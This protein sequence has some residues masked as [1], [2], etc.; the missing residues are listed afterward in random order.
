MQDDQGTGF[1]FD[2]GVSV[3]GV[4]Q[5]CAQ[6]QEILA[7]NFIGSLYKLQRHFGWTRCLNSE[8]PSQFI[9]ELVRKSPQQAK[10]T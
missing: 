8:Y 2:V 5:Y 3:I 4:L 10:A 7:F 9:L 6:V 1:D